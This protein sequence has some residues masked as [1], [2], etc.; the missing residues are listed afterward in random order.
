METNEKENREVDDFVRE[1]VEKVVNET[2]VLSETSLNRVS[3][4]L[5]QDGSVKS[6][7]WQPHHFRLY[8]DF[9]K[10]FFNQSKPTLEFGGHPINSTEFEIP[11]FMNHRIVIKKNLIELGNKIDHKK[12]YSIRLDSTASVQ[13]YDICV[14]KARESIHV[15]KEFV[16]RFGGVSN[17]RLMNFRYQWKVMNE[18]VVDKLPLKLAYNATLTSKVYNEKNIEGD[19]PMASINYIENAALKTVQPEIN[20]RLDRI[21]SDL[22]TFRKDALEPLTEQIKLHLKVQRKTL[23]VQ[24]A[25]LETQRFNVVAIRELAF[26]IKRLN[27]RGKLI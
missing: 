26:M 4:G 22:L 21:D 7:W 12:W 10:T 24:Q 5:V 14:K 20:K 23:K 8:F 2:G 18:E 11:D 6:L 25:Q 27:N 19:E 1:V 9:N 16:K 13:Q 17:F 15:L 3:V